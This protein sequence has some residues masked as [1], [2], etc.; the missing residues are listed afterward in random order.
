VFDP[1]VQLRGAHC[2]NTLRNKVRK[3]PS[4][5]DPVAV[6]FKQKSKKF[7]DL[8]LQPRRAAA[9]TTARTRR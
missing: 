3:G 5:T 4:D 2:L 1:A 6:R 7:I 8:L 9:R